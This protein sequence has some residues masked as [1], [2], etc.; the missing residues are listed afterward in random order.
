[1][2]FTLAATALL[3]SPGPGIA[4]LIAV[5]RSRGAIGGLRYFGSMQL[6]LALAAGLSAAGL[7]AVIRAFPVIHAALM[8]VSVAYLLWL[9]WAIASAPLSGSIGDDAPSGAFTLPG[10]FML[11]FANPKAYLAFAS[12]FGSFAILT[13]AYGFADG[14]LKWT[15]CVVV[16]AVV[17]LAWL[18]AGVALGRL[19]LTP[20]AERIMNLA[21]G[22]AILLA[23]IAAL[24]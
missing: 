6:G 12:L 7:V 2:V 10:G 3:G 4:A 16:M 8:I 19:T 21:M 9:A 24:A 14:L 22:G 20:R 11:G 13:P 15:L 1:M 17:D 18:L 23:C 5:G